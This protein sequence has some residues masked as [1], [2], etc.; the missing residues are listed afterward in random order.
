MTVR[1]LTPVYEEELR[2]LVA[3]KGRCDCSFAPCEHDTSGSIATLLGEIDR[4]REWFERRTP[5]LK[6]DQPLDDAALL[7]I[8]QRWATGPERYQADA[9]ALITTVLDQRRDAAN[10]QAMLDAAFGGKKIGEEW[11][12][13]QLVTVEQI[14]EYVKASH[15]LVAE[16]IACET[17]RAD[18]AETALL[19]LTNATKAALQSYKNAPGNF[20]EDGHVAAENALQAIEEALSDLATLTEPVRQRLLNDGI[21]AASQMLRASADVYPYDSHWHSAIDL[22]EGRKV[23]PPRDERVRALQSVHALCRATEHAT[24]DAT[25]GH[26]AVQIQKM[27]RVERSEDVA[28]LVY[29]PP[30]PPFPE[31]YEVLGPV[32]TLTGAFE[33]LRCGMEV[34]ESIACIRQVLMELTDQRDAAIQGARPSAAWL[35][36]VNAEPRSLVDNPLAS[37][38]VDAPTSRVLSA[39]GPLVDWAQKIASEAREAG[40]KFRVQNHK[41]SWKEVDG[42]PEPRSVGW[43]RDPAR[44]T[45]ILAR[46]GPPPVV[47]LG[48]AQAFREA[49]DICWSGMGPK[50]DK[51]TLALQSA[52]HQLIELA[53]KAEQ[54]DP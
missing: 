16:E 39:G 27:L 1:E 41:T 43:V 10:K 18:T 38:K 32:F 22:L 26:I 48:R 4:L 5:W 3:G 29:G 25:V 11:C 33:R 51:A 2:Y 8:Q 54:V 23:H 46:V 24:G 17:R 12:R 34:A 13:D 30:T 53:K 37:T 44:L 40:Y 21:E 36:R 9:D 47:A 6:T 42:D 50:P 15:E 14:T 45:N 49:A 20:P 31:S 52:A 7:A 19:G 28:G 35:A